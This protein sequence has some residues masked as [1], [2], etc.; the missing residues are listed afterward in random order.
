LTDG[1]GLSAA[2]AT[3]FAGKF[4][5]ASLKGRTGWIFSLPSGT[6]NV[7]SIQSCARIFVFD[8]NDMRN[9]KL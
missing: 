2:P 7:P 5:G 9:S 3:G 4:N 1:E 6:L 8:V